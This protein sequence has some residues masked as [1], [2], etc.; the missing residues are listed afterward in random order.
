VSRAGWQTLTKKT[1]ERGKT[2]RNTGEGLEGGK[3]TAASA[4][5]KEKDGSNKTSQ[6]RDC[7]EAS[8]R[9]NSSPRGPA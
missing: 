2:V 8:K 6:S 4:D 5:I 9:C 3:D 7:G 1:S